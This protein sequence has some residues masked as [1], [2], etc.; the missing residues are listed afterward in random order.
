MAIV[1]LFVVQFK[2]V[3]VF[4]YV[5]IKWGNAVSAKIVLSVPKMS[6]FIPLQLGVNRCCTGHVW[7][8]LDLSDCLVIYVTM[9]LII[10]AGVLF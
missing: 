2:M 6:F 8:I 5:V 4:Y 1:S 9:S 10:I 7:N 3:D